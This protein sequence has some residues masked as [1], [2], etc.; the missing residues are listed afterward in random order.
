ML[1]NFARSHVV[2]IEPDAPL[3]EAANLMT[4]RNVGCLVVTSYQ[5]PIGIITDRDLVTR[6]IHLGKDLYTTTVSEVMSGN[7]YVLEEELSL[8]EAL[9][10]MKDK[11]VRRFPVVDQD[12]NLTGFFSIDDVLYL[13]AIELSAVRR[14]IESEGPEA[15]VE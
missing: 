11:G 6:A 8:F 3:K 12:G 5:K 9:E 7:P 1:L 14:I 10:L 4:N 15:I 2:T 13:L